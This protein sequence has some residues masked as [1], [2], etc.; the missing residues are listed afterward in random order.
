MITAVRYEDG[1]YSTWGN[2]IRLTGETG[3]AGADGSDMEY[4]YILKTSQY[5]FPTNEKPANI[6]TGE[7]SPGQHAASG[8]ET[9]SQLDDWVP[10]GW[11][12]N[13][14]SVSDTYKYEYMSWRKKA[15]GGNSWG[16]FSDPI[17]WSHWG[18]N[19]M[20]G[21]GVQYVYKLFATE[22]SDAE[23]TSNIPTMP[24]SMTDGEWIPTGWSDD[25]LAPT[26]STPFCY[27]SVIKCIGGT[28]GNFEKLGL[29]SKYGK[30]GEPGAGQPDYIQTQEAWS[31]AESV[32]SITTMP[33][34]CTES[35]WSDTTPANS[36][37]KP[38]LW[39]RSRKM[40][41]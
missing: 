34:D 26:E 22:L 5:T 15:L 19:G 25:P 10:N 2:A 36:S 11:W 21:D 18:E 16:T 24:E 7:V 40:V 32:A 12:D 17:V 38:Y 31:N 1:T 9:D 35:S 23:R 14:R 20:D 41:L 30:D 33:S 8:S 6:T 29:W 4:I 39:R 3:E 37:N 28:W 27:C 13:P